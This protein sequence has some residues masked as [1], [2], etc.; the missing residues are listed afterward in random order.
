MHGLILVGSPAPGQRNC[1]F[2][3]MQAGLPEQP[4]GTQGHLDF[5]DIVAGQSPEYFGSMPLAPHPGRALHAPVGDCI[6]SASAD[7][8]SPRQPR[9]REIFDRAFLFAALYSPLRRCADGTVRPGGATTVEFEPRC[10]ARPGRLRFSRPSAAGYLIVD[11]AAHGL[12][13]GTMTLFGH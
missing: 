7:R 2:Y 6:F 9:H 3:V 11:G 5:S 8:I 1:E 10:R 12:L 4:F 13:E